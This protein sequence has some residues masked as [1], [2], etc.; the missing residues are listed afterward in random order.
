MLTV[1]EKYYEEEPDWNLMKLMPTDIRIQKVNAFPLTR[2]RLVGDIGLRAFFQ[3]YKGAKKII[4][5]EKIDFIFIPVPSFYCALLGPLLHRKTGV[6]YGIDYIDP[7]VHQFPGSEKV[8][9]RHWFST[10]LAKK[11]EP[12]AVKKASFL[13]GVAQGYYLPVFERNP[14]LKDKILHGAMPYGGEITDH[15]ALQQ[16]NLKAYLFPKNDKLRFVYAGAM[17]PKAFEPLKA[18]FSVMAENRADFEGVEFHFIGTGNRSNDAQSFTIKPIAL[19]YGL[20]E[21][22]VY[23]HPKRIPYLDVLVHLDAANAALVLGSTEA[24][25]TPSKVYQAVLAGKPIF[26][27]LH[28]ESTAVQVIRESDA[29]VVLD[30]NGEIDIDGI[31]RRFLD[32][33]N[34]FREFYRKFNPALV[35]KSKFDQHSAKN[36]TRKLVDLLNKAIEVYK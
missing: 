4:E 10:L 21:T 31:R 36:V 3:L 26:A 35:N 17:L 1:H 5:T 15:E 34:S 14:G 2:P 7:W 16:L 13:T 6:P 30:F 19:Q 27:V 8:F 29:G 33:F 32:S 9:S 20:W 22:I 11:L 25:Y 23:E 12:I 18:I 24:H 28:R